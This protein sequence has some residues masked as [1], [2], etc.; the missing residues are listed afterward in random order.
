MLGLNMRLV[1]VGLLLGLTACSAKPTYE[2]A[3]IQACF[4]RGEAALGSDDLFSREGAAF[5]DADVIYIP[6]TLFVRR[7]LN[8]DGNLACLL[9]AGGEITETSW[10]G[11]TFDYGDRRIAGTLDQWHRQKPPRV[12]SYLARGP[13]KAE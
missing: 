2:E 5:V 4:A 10:N 7:D 12:A 13:S 3:L 11:L 8:I 1:I 6:S 9:S